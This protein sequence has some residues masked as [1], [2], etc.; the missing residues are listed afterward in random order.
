[1]SKTIERR[2]NDFQN[3]NIKLVDKDSNTKKEK[4]FD[5]C[6]ISTKGSNESRKTSISST[7]EVINNKC[8]NNQNSKILE[9]NK[10][11]KTNTCNIANQHSDKLKLEPVVIPCQFCKRLGMTEVEK[12]LNDK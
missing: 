8:D 10:I 5:T 9:T 7:S 3:L 1:M 12:R 11:T 2:D 6:S 4:D